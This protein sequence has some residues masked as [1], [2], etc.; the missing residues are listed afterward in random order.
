MGIQ[1]PTHTLPMAARDVSFSEETVNKKDW[2]LLAIGHGTL[3]PVQVQKLMFLFRE[4]TEVPSGEAYEFV[5][6]DWG[7]CSFDIYDDLDNLI[8]LDMI[9]RSQS[10]RGV[11]RYS[12]TD[13]GRK[14]VAKICAEA[15][16]SKSLRNELQKWRNWVT[17]KSFKNTLT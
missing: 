9:A 1:G 11:S 17:S 12:L 6:Y 14:E 7:P 2:L 8:Q 15:D 13:A 3:E 16:K 4:K 5:P 10:P